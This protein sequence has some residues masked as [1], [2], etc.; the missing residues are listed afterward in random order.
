MPNDVINTITIGSTTYDIGGTGDGHV[1]EK[2]DGTDMTQRANLQF[3][4]ATLT[5]DSTNDRTVVENVHVID[6]EDELDDLPDGIY[7]GDY[8]DTTPIDASVIAYDNTTSGLT[9]DNVQ[10]A[11]DELVDETDRMDTTTTSASGNPISIAGLKSNQ[12]AIDPVLTFEPIQDLHGQSKPY[13]AGGGKN[14]LPLIVDDIKTTNTDGTWSGDAYTLN[15]VTF[16]LL[17][18]NGNNI[19]GIKVS[20]TASTSD[21][22]SLYLARAYTVAQASI[23]TGCPA[24]GSSDSYRLS[25]SGVGSDIGSGR[26]LSQGE[27]GNIFIYRGNTTISGTLTFY[28]MIRLATESDATFAPYENICPISGYDKI[29][30]SSVGAKVWDGILSNGHIDSNGVYVS[31]NS[32]AVSDYILVTPD[33]YS[34]ISD[35]FKTF[36][37]WY[38]WAYDANKIYINQAKSA[39][40]TT[41]TGLNSTFTLTGNTRYIRIQ[42]NA[43]GQ[44]SA[45][46]DSKIYVGLSTATQDNDYVIATS[47]SESLGQTVYGG[48]LDLRSG[49]FKVEYFYKNAKD[50]TWTLH[51]TSPHAMASLSGASASRSP[52]CSHY[53]GVVSS[54][55]NLQ[56]GEIAWNSGTLR[57][58]DSTHTT[59]AETWD[60]WV[61]GN[62]IQMLFELATPFTIQLT[63][64]ELTLLKTY[65]YLSTNGSNIQLSYHNGEMASLG[66]VSQLGET[67]NELGFSLIAFDVPIAG[68]TISSG[69]KNLYTTIDINSY[70]PI[71]LI[72][73]NP[74][75]EKCTFTLAYTNKA[76]ISIHI[77]CTE[78]S[79]T[80][81]SNIAPLTVLCIPNKKIIN[82]IK[83]P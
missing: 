82:P 62:D 16:T 37:A 6:D 12:L 80:I 34:I 74:W 65:A 60:E 44:I 55:I 52:I 26:N 41:G 31:D 83:Q 25:I 1:I 67:L 13:P 21:G 45:N 78:A 43:T 11:I 9:A 39:S 64:R 69:Y 7:I 54:W 38:V 29:D 59:S 10:D 70:T 68:E 40:H 33:T 58:Y 14:K 66:D 35:T 27:T 5:D 49:K 42:F 32:N 61:N 17:T 23:M 79:Y 56:E 50:L 28:P 30:I 73:Q 46:T 75:N 63:P 77:R 53:K 76:V 71:S 24:N 2:S 48:W 36:N 51:S 47:I 8:D 18:D 4:D 3:V 19:I 57:I 81:P 72:E 15:G 20:G 22:S